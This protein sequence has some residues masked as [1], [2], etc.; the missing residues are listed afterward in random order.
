MV[1]SWAT[2]GLAGRTSDDCCRRMAHRSRLNLHIC[3]H[4][5]NALCLC[6]AHSRIFLT[7]WHLSCK[8]WRSLET[9]SPPSES[10][11]F[12]CGLVVRPNLIVVK[13]IRFLHHHIYSNFSSS[14]KIVDAC[15]VFCRINVPAW[16]NSPPTWLQ[17]AISQKL[18]NRSQSNFQH[19]ISGYPGGYTV[20]CIEIRQG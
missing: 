14:P 9:S 19:L 8:F 2:T 6:A 4:K 1:L 16:I 20:N 3:H 17:L 7:I 5:K 13:V 18:L 15:T 10:H 12:H 11:T